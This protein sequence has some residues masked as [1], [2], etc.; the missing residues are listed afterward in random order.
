[1]SDEMRAKIHELLDACLDSDT[2]VWFEYHPHTNSVGTHRINRKH[3][4]ENEDFEVI[5]GSNVH[6][7]E[8]PEQVEK[9]IKKV[10]EYDN[11][12]V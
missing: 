4:N 11:E 7:N 5:G 10:K 3:W 9:L 2:D 6:L 12:P 8:S 1:M